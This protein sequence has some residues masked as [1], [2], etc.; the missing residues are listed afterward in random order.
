MQIK[1]L[2]AYRAEVVSQMT[3]VSN[4]DELTA[5]EKKQIFDEIFTKVKKLFLRKCVE[6][7]NEVIAE[8]SSQ[9]FDD[10]ISPLAV[11]IACDKLSRTLDE[12]V[13][14]YAHIFYAS[15]E[16]DTQIKNE[17]ARRIEQAKKAKIEN[18][19]LEHKSEID[20][21]AQ[22]LAEL[23]RQKQKQEHLQKRA[24]MILDFESEFAAF[25]ENILRFNEQIKIDLQLA[26]GK[27]VCRRVYSMQIDKLLREIQ[28]FRKQENL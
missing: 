23:E 28:E 11:G 15:L 1:K 5:H 17:I 13:L 3:A 16:F 21:Q 20:K 12:F 2:G 4:F 7:K 26:K 14:D 9:L 18:Y 8:I 22:E 10:G 25:K 6:G 24:N 19:F 27:D